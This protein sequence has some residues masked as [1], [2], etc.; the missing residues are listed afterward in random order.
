MSYHQIEDIIEE[1]IRLVGNAKLERI[2]KR[3]LIHNLYRF[4]DRFDTSYTRFRV[5]DILKEARYLYEWPV[6]AHPDYQTHHDFFNAFKQDVAQWIPSDLSTDSE[7]IYLKG[8]SIFFEAGDAFW[9]RVKAQLA[10]DDQQTPQDQPIPDVFLQLLQLAEALHDEN[11]MQE[12]YAVFAN[13]I[14]EFDLDVEDGI[15]KDFSTWLSNKTLLS[16]R[17]FAENNSEILCRKSEDQDKLL[18][19]PSLQEEME[20]ASSADDMAKLSFLLDLQAPLKQIK[21]TFRKDIAFKPDFSKYDLIYTF[22]R[23]KLDSA[24]QDGLRQTDQETGVISFLKKIRDESAK[25]EAIYT[26]IILELTAEFKLVNCRIGIQN[27]IILN[28]QNREASAEPKKQHFAELLLAFVDEKELEENKHLTNWGGWKYSLKHSE[29]TLLKRL[30]NLWQTYERYSPNIYSFY[31][32]PLTIWLSVED[33]DKLMQKR[34]KLLDKGYSFFGN[35]MEFKLA[36]ACLHKQSGK[37]KMA[38]ELS[39]EVSRLLASGKGSEKLK[40]RVQQGL[41][42]IQTGKGYFPE[43]TTIYTLKY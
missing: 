2:E 41:N 3:N 17:S 15:P 40:I 33:S 10:E 32:A 29:K 22:F 36:T 42:Y 39:E 14:L 27:G 26:C 25:Q 20:L 38:E 13:S 11:F 12:W 24:W 7:S 8:Q 1:A 9:Q 31:E 34:K 37:T 18:S 16:I 28:W 35:E 5:L 6:D 4:H 21:A 23:E 43:L 19:L 30:E